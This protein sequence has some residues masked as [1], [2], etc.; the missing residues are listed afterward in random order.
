MDSVVTGMTW[1]PE[2]SGTICRWADESWQ[3]S[4]TCI[5]SDISCTLHLQTVDSIAIATP[6]CCRED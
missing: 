1:D 3:H 6:W 2:G 4:A 5:I